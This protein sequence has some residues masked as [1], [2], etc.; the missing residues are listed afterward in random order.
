METYVPNVAKPP[1]VVPYGQLIASVAKSIITGHPINITNPITLTD[2]PDTP[3]GAVAF[4]ALQRVQE[5]L[6]HGFLTDSNLSGPHRELWLATVS[7]ILVYIHNSIRRTHSATPLPDAFSDLSSSETSHFNLLFTAISSL[8]R[9]FTNRN[10]NLDPVDGERETLEWDICLRC[11]EETQHPCSETHYDSVLKSCSSNVQAAHRTII[12]QKLQE[13]SSELE[14]WI[15]ARRES[16]KAGFL[17]AVISDNFS[18]FHEAD[19]PKLLQ[20]AQTTADSFR[21]SAKRFIARDLTAEITDPF[22]IELLTARK[23][24][25]DTDLDKYLNSYIQ[26][27]WSKAETTA[28]SDTNIFYNETLSNLKAEA[29]ERAEREV[30]EYK[31]NLKVAAEERKLVL[32]LDFEKY[33]PK[34]SSSSKSAAWKARHERADPLASPS[35]AL[36]ISRSQSRSHAPSL[37]SHA[38]G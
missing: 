10:N 36:S 15:S 18:F 23:V 9:F 21:N 33:A 19:N 11:L 17:D 24:K 38:P 16:I 25:V 13:L 2:F 20:W 37:E 31:S 29:L 35:P 32:L 26:S 4:T 22:F 12:N 27:E 8:S 28:I 14:D 1:V 30:A 7:Q 34:P 6:S 3:Q 5:F